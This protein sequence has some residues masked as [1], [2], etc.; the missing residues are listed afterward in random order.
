MRYLQGRREED[1]FAECVSIDPEESEILEF[2]VASKHGHVWKQEHGSWSAV[3]SQAQSLRQGA[4]TIVALTYKDEFLR[5]D[6]P[7]RNLPQPQDL[8]TE[9]ERLQN[10]VRHLQ[11]DLLAAQESNNKLI[12]VVGEFSKANKAMQA[13]FDALRGKRICLYETVRGVVTA[14]ESTEV[15]VTYETPEGETRQIYESGR[16]PR[17]G[18]TVE[19]HVML[20]VVQAPLPEPAPEEFSGKLSDFIDRGSDDPIE[21]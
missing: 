1:E 16:L 18:D 21:I 4:G 14:Q 12:D 3:L 17:E 5:G 7:E 13:A 15:E 2:Y 20:S 8:Q 11:N 19:A 9:N 6:A 10:R